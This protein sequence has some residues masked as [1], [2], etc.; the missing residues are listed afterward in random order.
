MHSLRAYLLLKT[1]DTIATD[2]VNNIRQN[3]EQSYVTGATVY[4]WY[5]AFIEL[6]VTTPARVTHI[7]NELKR[8]QPNLTHIETVIEKP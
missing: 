6:E 8:T 5:D 3:Y 4:G 2:I 1:R 7:I